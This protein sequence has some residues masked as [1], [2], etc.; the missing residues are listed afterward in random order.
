LY[1]DYRQRQGQ[2]KP[3]VEAV[4]AVEAGKAVTSNQ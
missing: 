1:S 4:E 3:N 2:V